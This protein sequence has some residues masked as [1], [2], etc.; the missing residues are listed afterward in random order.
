MMSKESVKSSL[1]SEQGMSYTEFTYQ[2]L[3]GY[4]FLY[5]YHKEGVHVQ[6][7]CSDQW[8]NITAGTDL[9]GRKILQPNPNAYGLTFT[10]LLKSGGTKFGKSEDGA[11]WLSPSMLFPC[12]F[13]QHFFSVPD[14]DV[15]R[16]LKTRTF[17]SMEEIG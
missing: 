4:D 5:L 9:I 7:G 10:L 2:L 6:I 1:E 12:K 11:V 17:L 3:Q 14:A 8:G 13:Y 16:F 15:T